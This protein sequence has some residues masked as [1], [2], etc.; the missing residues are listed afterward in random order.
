MCSWKLLTIFSA[1]LLAGCS[2]DAERLHAFGLPIARI[3]LDSEALSRLNAT[4]TAKVPVGGKVR[5]GATRLDAG[6]AYSGRGT[7]DDVKKS[8]ELTFHGDARYRDRSSYRLAAQ[9]SD[10]TG[11]KATIGFAA[12]A[13][14][15]LPV[16]A[17]EPVV[18]YLNG[19][20]QGL[21]HLLEP[22]D[23]E[24]YGLRGIPLANLLKAK[25]GNATFAPESL[26]KL[27]DA[28]DSKLDPET[29]HD[30]RELILAINAEASPETNATLERLLDLDS[31]FAYIAVTVLLNQWDG[32][33]NNF[34]LHRAPGSPRFAWTP[35][36]LDRLQD[37]TSPQAAYRAGA[38]PFGSGLLCQRIF[39]VPEWRAR[40]LELL[41]K[42]LH[43]SLPLA[44]ME[45]RID[46]ASARISEAFA[47]DAVLSRE[48]R[49]AAAT[50]AELKA[51]FA[52]WYR[53]LQ[54]DLKQL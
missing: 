38:T 54:E 14:L 41:R 40:Y 25:Y 33:S 2:S 5:I 29:D 13:A 1:A 50:A 37:K 36:D 6:I 26:A 30:L 11:V 7:L 52:A 19:I 53:Q 46:T 43:E 44:S 3:D 20:Y 27:E 51:Q 8:Y 24:F 48:A 35:W 18:L 45:E 15:G 10:G 23:P 28:F 47:A 12:Y 16:P 4:V 31:F 39:A 9:S 34:F 17:V 49:T 42:G 21:Y 22:V 32:F